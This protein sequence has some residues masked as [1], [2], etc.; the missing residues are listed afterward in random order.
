MTQKSVEKSESSPERC[1]GFDMA[2][3][4]FFSNV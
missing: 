3:P 4:G 2:E 1:P